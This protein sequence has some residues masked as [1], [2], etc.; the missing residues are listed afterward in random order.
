MRLTNDV[1][2]LC[3]V[4]CPKFVLLVRFFSS[5]ESFHKR[6]SCAQDAALEAL[7]QEAQ[8]AK[9]EGV[10]IDALEAA[11]LHMSFNVANFTEA[12]Q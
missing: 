5:L 7:K 4:A 11:T 3:A 2:P 6:F 9:M 1:I 8:A 12:F 10:G